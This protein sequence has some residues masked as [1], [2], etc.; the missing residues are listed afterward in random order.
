MKNFEVNWSKEELQTYLF[1][2]CINADY[3]E[4]KE[5]LEAISLKTNQ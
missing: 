1:I 2:Y 3:K 5:E 4:T